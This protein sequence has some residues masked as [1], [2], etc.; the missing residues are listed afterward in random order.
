MAIVSVLTSSTSLLTA[1]ARSKILL[2]NRG[3]NTIWCIF[4][5]TAVV[6]SGFPL[7][8]GEQMTLEVN[9]SDINGTLNA[10]AETGATNLSVYE[11]A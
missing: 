11:I 6:N 8:T 3:A 9:E 1:S 10:I 5:A 7:D 4:D 2:D